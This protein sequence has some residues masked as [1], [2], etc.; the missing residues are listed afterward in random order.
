[1]G[2]L[3]DLSEEWAPYK[4][5]REALA[6]DCLQVRG[7]QTRAVL[8]GTVWVCCAAV[9]SVCDCACGLACAMR[10]WC[11]VWELVWMCVCDCACGCACACAYTM[12]VMFV[13]FAMMGCWLR[14]RLAYAGLPVRRFDCAAQ[15]RA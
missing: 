15:E 6:M 12:P 2:I 9:L 8:C 7:G 11:G 5:A 1:M 14:E 13:L 4:A 10:C 3:A